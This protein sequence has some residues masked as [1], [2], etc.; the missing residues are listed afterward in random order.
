MGQPSV[1]Y[2]LYQGWGSLSG[3]SLCKAGYSLSQN[4]PRESLPDGRFLGLEGGLYGLGDGLGQG[5]FDLDAPIG[6]RIEILEV[7]N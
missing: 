2:L 7:C 3:Y 6:R 5:G 1:V 4:V